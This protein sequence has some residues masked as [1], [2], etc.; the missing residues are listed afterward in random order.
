[1]TRF[2]SDLKDAREG[3]GTEV[4]TKRKAELDRLWKEGKACKNGF[5]RQCIAQEY[6][7]L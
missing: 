7:R 3:N 4:L 6:T 2:E 5:R 1:M